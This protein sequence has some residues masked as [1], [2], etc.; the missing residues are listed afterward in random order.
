M[1]GDPSTPITFDPA[2]LPEGSPLAEAVKAATANAN[3]PVA[4]GDD[5]EALTDGKHYGDD[6]PFMPAPFAGGAQ[7]FD[8]YDRYREAQHV[9][10]AVNQQTWTFEMLIS[11]VM[12]DDT[13]TAAEKAI[14]IRDLASDLAGRVSEA[15]REAVAEGIRETEYRE[16][17]AEGASDPGYFHAF[18]DKAGDLRWL[19]V[20][21]NNY[22]D[23]EGETFSAKSHGEFV[24]WVDRTKAFPS[25]RLWH[26][27][28][29]IGK[30]DM[31]DFDGTFMI[32]SGT[33]AKEY[34]YIGEALKSREE[35]IGCSHGF[36]Y[37]P[38]DLQGGVYQRYRSFEV[39]VLPMQVAANQLTA[40]FARGE[41]PQMNEAKREWITE[42]AGPELVAT[43]ETGLGELKTIADAKGV[44]YKEMADAVIALKD[45]EP[46]AAT[47]AAPAPVAAT[48]P[49]AT[50]E[51][52]EPE[53]GTP[54][55]ETPAE[56]EPEAVKE[57]AI[58]TEVADT[59][60]A[61][62]TKAM[63]PLAAD[64]AEIKAKQLGTDAAVADAIR[65]GN[66]PDVAVAH[67]KDGAELPPEVAAALKQTIDAPEQGAKSV[68]P[69]SPYVG[70]LGRQ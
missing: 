48:E 45:D 26:M 56:T 20:H 63:E 37:R 64:V 50:P 9:E 13:L 55:P 12:R 53:A 3:A 7:T 6:A 62:V 4:D 40:F 44:T 8:E 1:A 34:E 43:M 30:A 24:E 59:L 67:S 35:A 27:P 57:T 69:S 33:F 42:L 65:P 29:D 36:Q 66:A 22:Q 21:S 18:R 31:V 46:P 51:V 41:L 16:E 17:H 58:P 61:I 14:K 28:H 60:L 70:M 5:P 15:E 32:S 11:N 68:D 23:R 54:E 38:Q 25:L 19:A 49:E 52:T 39:S 47:E 10:G 2:N